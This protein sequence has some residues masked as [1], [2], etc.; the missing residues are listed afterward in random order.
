MKIGIIPLI[1]ITLLPH[2]VGAANNIPDEIEQLIKEA[3]PNLNIGVKITNLD[4]GKVIFEKNADRYFIP[5][6][7][8]KFVTIVAAL[9]HFGENYDFTSKLINKNQDYYLHIHDPDFG[10]DDLKYFVAE[11]A[12]HSNKNIKGNIYIID[13]KFSVPATMRD[14][15]FSDSLYCY[16]APITL[17]HINKNCSKLDVEPGELGGVIKIISHPNF[18]Y[19]IVNNTKT[20]AKNENDRLVVTIKEGKYIIKGTLSQ[21]TGPVTIAA[22]A[23]DNLSQIKYHLKKQLNNQGVALKG[24]ILFS[25]DEVKGEKAI[26]SLSKNIKDLAAKAMKKSDNFITD[27]FLAEF[28]SKYGVTEW[29]W[30]AAKLKEV[31]KQRFNV[32]LTKSDIRD[33]SGISRQNLLTVHQFDGLLKAVVKSEKFELVKSILASPNDD[34]TLHDRFEHYDIYAKTGSLTGISALVGYFYNSKKELHSFVI[35]ANNFY[36][37]RLLYHKLEGD[38]IKLVIQ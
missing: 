25:E 33:G 15:T 2:I 7:T 1:I 17:V 29:D 8:L 36:Q 9:E 13:N 37:N 3:D 14:K 23:N 32:D 35:M 38:I 10:I 27:Y 4:Q 12:K 22:V 5:A 21:S 11:V 24:K 16:G 20:I 6:S 18:P 28:A 26:A 19:T 31:A 30:A 34:S